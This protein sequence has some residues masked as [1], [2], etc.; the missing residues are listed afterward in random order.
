MVHTWGAPGPGPTAVTTKLRPT[1]EPTSPGVLDSAAEGPGRG[2]GGPG[3]T[4]SVKAQP[5][6]PI[7]RK[8]LP[9]SVI[10]GMTGPG[11]RGQGCMYLQIPLTGA[12][13]GELCPQGL[14]VLPMPDDTPAPGR[15]SFFPLFPG[16]PVPSSCK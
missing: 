6:V 9:A 16:S 2:S 10:T 8:S 15:S 3:V 7:L 12:T 1:Q 14:G 4:S 13:R 5:H 11:G